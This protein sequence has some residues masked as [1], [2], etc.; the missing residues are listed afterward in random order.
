M[1]ALI[2]DADTVAREV[3]ELDQRGID[4]AT[5]FATFPGHPLRETMQTWETFAGTVM[6]HLRTRTIPA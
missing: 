4:H 2:K 3:T 1:Q 6:P 5:F